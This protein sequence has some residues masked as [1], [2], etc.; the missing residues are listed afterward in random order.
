MREFNMTKK[1]DRDLKNSSVFESELARVAN[2]YAPENEEEDGVTRAAK[3]T[4]R[5]LAVLAIITLIALL[6]VDFREW[7]TP[8]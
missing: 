4:A 7:F 3:K 2:T 1:Q 6:A 8:Q 5:V